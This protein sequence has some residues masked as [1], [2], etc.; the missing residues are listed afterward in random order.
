MAVH[1]NYEDIQGI[2]HCTMMKVQGGYGQYH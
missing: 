2:A 1:K